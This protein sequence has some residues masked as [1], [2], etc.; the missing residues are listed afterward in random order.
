[1]PS[2]RF[3][4]KKN[5]N[6]DYKETVEKTKKIILDFKFNKI[7]HIS[8]ISARCQLNTIYGKNKKLSEELIKKTKKYIIIRLGAMYGKGLTKGVLI[9]MIN[10][11]TVYINGN[12]KYSFTDVLWNSKWIIKNLNL[13][14]KLVE[15]GA[16]DYIKLNKLSKFINSKSEF[17]G[18]IDNQ[19]I[20]NKSYKYN[21]IKKLIHFIKRKK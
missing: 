13:K 10:N 5:P 21:S 11:K 15:V 19:V 2:K 14:N 17:K 4:A 6:L 12:S 1:M 7:V 8:S 20:K 16:T 3:W 9:D 18:E